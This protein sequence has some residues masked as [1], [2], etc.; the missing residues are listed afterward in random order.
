M[1]LFG[2]VSSPAT[3]VCV[4]IFQQQSAV[5]AHAARLPP[6]LIHLL[7]LCCSLTHTETHPLAQQVNFIISEIKKK[8]QTMKS[9]TMYKQVLCRLE[10]ETKDRKVF[11]DLVLGG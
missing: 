10:R 4:L 7:S 9:F 8:H 3:G 1:S 5:H 6:I 2:T 11:I